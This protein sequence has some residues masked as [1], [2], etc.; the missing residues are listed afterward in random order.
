MTL[1]VCFS[2]K[3]SF[4]RPARLNRASCRFAPRSAVESEV[5][6]LRLRRSHSAASVMSPSFSPRATANSN[7]D[8]SRV[9]RHFVASSGGIPAQSVVRSHTLC[10]TCTPRSCCFDRKRYRSECW[11]IFKMKIAFRFGESAGFLPEQKHARSFCNQGRPTRHNGHTH[12]AQPTGHTWP[13]GPT[14]TGHTSHTGHNPQCTPGGHTG[15]TGHTGHRAPQLQ[16]GLQSK[17][18][19]ISA[20]QRSDLERCIFVVSTYFC[21]II[22]GLIAPRAFSSMASAIFLFCSFVWS[23]HVSRCFCVLCLG[24]HPSPPYPDFAGCVVLR[25][26][27]AHACG[28]D[29]SFLFS[30]V[31]R[32]RVCRGRWSRLWLLARWCY[33]RCSRIGTRRDGG[34]ARPKPQLRG[35][36]SLGRE[37]R[38]R[39][40]RSQRRAPRPSRAPGQRLP[41]CPRPREEIGG[42]DAVQRLMDEVQDAQAAQR[43][44]QDALPSSP[45]EF[46]PR[47]RGRAPCE[48]RAFHP[49]SAAR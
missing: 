21:V 43:E 34:G 37:A 5:C 33:G 19:I 48:L 25:I 38:L 23:P 45:P 2:V 46:A 6:A 24:L 11:R 14:H 36:R 7:Q 44:I 1:C 8:L 9:S 49:R 40:P 26:F 42:V 35:L 41:E 20:T 13:T 47:P 39:A 10:I 4:R 28:R 22:L 15:L 30:A 3:A 31:G 17:N 27:F 32:R 16:N 29:L 18:V 12:R